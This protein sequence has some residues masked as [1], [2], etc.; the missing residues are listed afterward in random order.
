MAMGGMRDAQS[1]LDN[2]FILWKII[3]QADVLEV[4]G[5]ASAQR[6]N[7]LKAAVLAGNYGKSSNHGRILPEGIGLLSCIARFIRT[8]SCKFN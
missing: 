4:Y 2:N 5:L 6:I 8:I 7:D 3:K 1:I